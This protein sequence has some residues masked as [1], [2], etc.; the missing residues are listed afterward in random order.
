MYLAMRRLFIEA[1]LSTLACASR[2]GFILKIAIEER[3][4][5]AMDNMLVKMNL[6]VS[7]LLL[8]APRADVVNQIK[9]KTV[10]EI[11]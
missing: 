8:A 7:V 6:V 5:I 11:G 1:Y 10:C 4:K 9:G 2:S 3:R